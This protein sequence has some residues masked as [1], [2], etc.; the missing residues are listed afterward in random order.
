M[1]NQALVHVIDDDDGVRESLRFLLESAGLTVHAHASAEAFLAADL[2]PAGCVLT[3]IRLPG[4]DGMELLRRLPAQGVR[5]PVIVMTGHADVPLAVQAMKAGAIDFLEKPFSEEA[6]IAAVERA[7]E[8]SRRISD[9]T[10]QAQQAHARL[11]TLTRRER[12]VF[13]LLVQ[14]LA[15]KAI[16]RALDASPRT[17]EVHRGRVMEKLSA[18][19]LPD[20]VRLAQTADGA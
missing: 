19:S 1:N 7:Q 10:A 4:M 11:A 2:D 16:A 14:G 8:A 15:N 3:D 18:H 5:L 13:D 20:L 6:L 9:S 17:I 12:Q